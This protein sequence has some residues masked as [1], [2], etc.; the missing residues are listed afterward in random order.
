MLPVAPARTSKLWLTILTAMVA[1]YAYFYFTRYDHFLDWRIESS[2]DRS[3]FSINEFSLGAFRFELP[4]YKYTISEEFL[5][6]AVNDTSHLTTPLLLLVGVGLSYL[7]AVFTFFRRTTFIVLFGLVALFFMSLQLDSYAIFGMEPPSRVGSGIIIFLYLGLGY[8]FHAVRNKTPLLIRFLSFA[9]L[10]ALLVWYLSSLIPQ[11]P[12]YIIATG[13]YG[14]T[15]IAILFIILVAEEI[16]Y[17]ILFVITQSRGGNSEKHFVAAS[18]VYL[19]F[20]TLYYLKKAGIY[21]N[22]PAVMDPFLLLVVSCLV[23][24]WSLRHKQ[25]F[26]SANVGVDIDLRHLLV[27]SGLVAFSYLSMGFAVG[28]DP[29]YE[30]FHYLITYIHLGFGAAFFLYIVLNFI[31]ALIAGH[32]VYKIAYKERNFP[33]LTCRLVGLIAVAAFFFQANREPFELAQAAKYNALGEHAIKNNEGPLAEQYFV[34]GAIS[35]YNNHLSNYQLAVAAQY[36]DRQSEAALRYRN[37]TKR[38]PTPQA[39]ANTAKSEANAGSAQVLLEQGVNTFPRS[40]QLGNNLAVSYANNG[41]LQEAV[42][43]LEQSKA[44]GEWNDATEVNRWKVEAQMGQQASQVAGAFRDGNNARKT[45]I[46][47][48]LIETKATETPAL[49]TAA[50]GGPLNLHD[51]TLI[52]NAAY[53]G[54]P[55][56]ST[57]IQHAIQFTYN[58]QLQTDLRIAAALNRYLAGDI[59]SAV[60]ALDG[61][62]LNANP[63]DKGN[64][65][66]ILGLITLEQGAYSTASQYLSTAYNNQNH[67]AGFALAVTLMEIGDMRQARKQWQDL[68]VLNPQFQAAYDQV[69]SVFSNEPLPVLRAYYEWSEQAPEQLL[70]GL[71]TAQA[72]PAFVQSIWTRIKRD[73]IANWD[74]TTYRR[75]WS[76]FRP[77]LDSM[78]SRRA[79]FDL[80]V[81]QGRVPTAIPIMANAFDEVLTTAQILSM[82]EQGQ[83]IEGFNHLAAASELFPSSTN[84]LMRYALMA[85]QLGLRDYAEDS[86]EQL[87]MLL[88]QEAFARFDEEWQLQVKASA[89]SSF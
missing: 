85:Y 58:P 83:E 57:V 9:I 64:M 55:I 31:D 87:R 11:L 79:R 16:I 2:T 77:H 23:A 24:I 21:P 28:N 39:F 27:G 72:S 66:Y 29:S 46:L 82:I 33:Y 74:A 81:L 53:T 32:N 84:Y 63:F 43:L 15:V 68:I 3:E 10:S 69:A 35:G 44:T 36:R 71:V 8:I 56:T 75:Y 22:L 62:L 50:F 67:D 78:S 6:S 14:F 37:A 26:F 42:Q 65:A 80:E 52:N 18:L 41:R 47:S 45:N 1:V 73:A 51:L 38:Y 25:E 19:L 70:A 20:L 7:L 86:R 54:A 30:T 61:L 40:G 76:A 88:D 5:G 59:N 49:D 13:T 48:H 4:G 89:D 60:Q 34:Q 17:A 12:S